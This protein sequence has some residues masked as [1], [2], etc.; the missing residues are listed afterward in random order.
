[1]STHYFMCI[2]NTTLPWSYYINQC[3]NEKL[4]SSQKQSWC[5]G[6]V[7][8]LKDV[9]IRMLKLISFN[10]Y[11]V[12]DGGECWGWASLILLLPFP[13]TF[14]TA[15]WNVSHSTNKRKWIRRNW[16]EKS[17]GWLFIWV[18]LNEHSIEIVL[19]Y[20][21]NENRLCIFINWAEKEDIREL[22]NI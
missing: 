4:S 15:R 1:M 14:D 18:W 6:G 11:W 9:I 3:G 12:S 20:S 10:M 17:Q 13:Q 19:K 5:D 2:N 7:V 22:V 21:W 16:M 8:L